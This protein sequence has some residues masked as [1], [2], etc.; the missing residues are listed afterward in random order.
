MTSATALLEALRDADARAAAAL[1]ESAVLSL[2]VLEHVLREDLPRVR[3]V[4]F[5]WSDQGEYLA[6]VSLWDADLLLVDYPDDWEIVGDV[7]AYLTAVNAVVWQPYMVSARAHSPTDPTDFVLDLAS[8][9][10]LPV[11]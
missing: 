1:S 8:L 10:D 9:K 6:S 5:A 3:Y 11:S 4:Q 2:A 7:A